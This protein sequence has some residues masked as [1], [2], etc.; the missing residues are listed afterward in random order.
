MKPHYFA[1]SRSFKVINV[2]INKKLVVIACYGKQHVCAY[3]CL[4]YT[5]DAADE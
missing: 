4:L 3:L 1:G 2:D 5:Y